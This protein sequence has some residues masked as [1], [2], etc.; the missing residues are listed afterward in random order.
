MVLMLLSIYK[1]IR[2]FV[3]N[4][5]LTTAFLLGFFVDLITLNKVDSV[6]DN[7][8]LF[9]YVCLALTSTLLL[10][11]GVAE[12]FGERTN[13]FLRKR[14]PLAMQYSF[15]GLLS[16]MLI[17]YG[18]SSSIEDSWP[19][20]LIFMA[21]IYG[22]ETIKQRQSRLLYNLV[23]LFIGLFAYFTLV[24][25]VFLGKMGPWIFVGSGLIALGVMYL[26]FKTLA[27]IVPNFMQL[28]RRNAVFLIGLIYISM[29]VM[30]FTNII[31]PIPLSLKHVG[32]YHSVV[33]YEDGTYELTYEDPKPWQIFRRSDKKFHYQP[34]DN[35]FCFAAVFAPARLNTQIYHRWEFLD[36][37]TGEWNEHG[38]Y[39]YSIQGGRG[40]GYR[41]YTLISNYKEGTWRCTIETERG[42]VI[43]REEFSVVG[44]TPEPF[45]TR[46]E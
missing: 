20:L 46:R 29:N 2:R 40:D 38:R 19:F 11:A 1:S 35:I 25:P 42:Q 21:V 36:P 17:F 9:F 18:R 15:G 7:I 3:K 32:I 33:R 44:G 24:I 28:Q 10:Y 4:H 6:F 30:Y 8:V 41:G 22:N 43:G 13:T 37:E 26:F 31:P 45:V 34:G 12:R 23:M 16:G 27:K 39:T 5:W 14:A